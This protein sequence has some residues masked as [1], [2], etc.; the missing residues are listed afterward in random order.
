MLVV[1]MKYRVLG[2]LFCTLVVIEDCDCRCTAELYLLSQSP[3]VICF[4]RWFPSIS[5]SSVP[6]H[7]CSSSWTSFFGYLDFL[8][9]AKI[10][11]LKTARRGDTRIAP[12]Y[13]PCLEF[14]PIYRRKLRGFLYLR[15][16]K[17]AL[18][19]RIRTAYLSS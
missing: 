17:D 12:L 15:Q 11:V 8:R 7:Q 4:L 13:Y 5:P 1:R 2:L 3:K 9:N 19:G 16:I 6:V 18:S 10:F 14:K